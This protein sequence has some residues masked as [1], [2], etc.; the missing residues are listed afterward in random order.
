MGA[1]R[2][3][4]GLVSLA[5]FPPIVKWAVRSLWAAA[6]GAMTVYGVALI[7]GPG[8]PASE[9]YKALFVALIVLPAC[10]CLVRALL[11]AEQRWPWAVCG[12]GMLCWAAGEVAFF[13]VIE[14]QESPPY[15]SIVDGLWIGYYGFSLAALLMLMKAGIARFRTSLWID[16]LVGALA[17]A[18]LAA[19]VVIEPVLDSTGAS[20]AAVAT[21]MAYPFIDVLIVGLLIAVFAISDGRVG[22]I[23]ALLAVVWTLQ[24]AL[25]IVYLLQATSGTY[26]FGTWLDFSWPALMLVIA[27]AAWHKPTVTTCAQEQGWGSLAMT[28]GFAVVGLT[29]IALDRWHALNSVAIILAALT[30]AAAFVHTAM[31]FADMRAL[32]SG[33]ELARERTLILDAAGEGI[34]GTDAAGRVTFMNPAGKRMTGYVPGELTGRSL[35][36]TL[37]H[38]KPDGSPYPKRDCPMH[39]SL[40]DGAIHHCDQ[41][42]YWRKDG[43]SFPVEYTSTPIADAT[44]IR[45]AVVVFHDVTQRR[46]L[47]HVKDEFT[48]VVSHELR[49]PLTSIRGSLGLLESG[50]L[51]PLSDRAQRMIQI[52]VQNTDRLVRLINDILD[53]ERLDADAMRLRRSTCDTE[54]L[55]GRATEAML[56]TALAAR[57]TLVVDAAPAKFEADADRIIQLLTNLIDNAVKFSPPGGTIQIGAQRRS[58]DI[59]FTVRDSGRGIPADK[60]ES[61]FGRFQQV[62]SSDSRQSGGTGLGLAICRSIVEHHGG[63]IWASS[64]PGEGSTFSFALPAAPVPA[65]EY[66][67][68]PGGTRGAVLICDDNAEIL[69]VIGT[70]L[71]EGG[72]HVIPALSGEEAIE[73][74]IAE[75]P[76]VI[77]LDLQLPGMSGVETVM[78]LR[79]HAETAAIPVIV[80]SVLPRSD[81]EMA[82]R[83]F[84]DWIEKPAA[85]EELFAALERAI[86]PVDDAY[87]AVFIERVPAVAETLRGLFTRHGVVSFAT[88]GGPE[89]AALCRRVRVDLLVL[90]DDVPA[91]D[92]VEIKRWLGLQKSLSDLPIVGFDALHVEAAERERRSVG[93]VTQ[94]LTK[95]HFTPEEFQWRVMTLLARPH[96]GR[97]A[98]DESCV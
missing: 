94:V 44:G 58:E 21:T 36:E 24:G 71:E 48:S 81:E 93:A 88:T 69:E 8:D 43:S 53:L 85:P 14:G 49:T 2:G 28:I 11:V 5:T 16:A 83:A 46:E 26:A 12:A 57:V 27:V 62:D 51:G 96:I 64:T 89:A 76:D 97:R 31:T 30:L 32:A 39:A 34:V 23:W 91:V 86:G 75:R 40:L 37:H 33:R 42:V 72:Y 63:R 13:Q 98:G 4:P 59:L 52:A 78:A 6:A 20:V 38:T 90:D 70:M 54:G 1:P 56:A 95:G 55:I 65:G 77:L 7:G 60:L 80:L 61:I 74:A 3:G 41:D 66:R 84:M 35:H 47:E 18:A 25:D 9:A 92:G 17:V 45:G 10:L 19:A 79:D 82:K 50:V 15:P 29:L 73:C 67:P 87:R 68:R 22:R